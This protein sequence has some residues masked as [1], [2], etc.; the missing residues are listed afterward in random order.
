[1]QM[2]KI[3]LMIFALLSTASICNAQILRAE[4]L[5]KYAKEKFGDNWTDAAINLSKTLNLDKNNAL[6]ISQVIEV[7]NKSK[8][9][10]YIL[11]NYWYSSTFNDANSVIQLNDKESGVI[12]AQGYVADIARHTGGMNRYIVNLSPIIKCDIKEGKARIT[13]TVPFYS[14]TKAAGG[15]LL[16]G[17][18]NQVIKQQ[19][20][21]LD[22]CFPFAKKDS[23]K[24]VSSKALVMAYA[25]S[26]VIM[27]KIE[28]CIKNGMNGNESDDW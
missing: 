16:F 17:P 24:Q 20:W 2:K 1:M 9:D 21:V 27:D 7:P 25:Y 15:G 11:L 6:T 8:Q 23:H 13:Y 10:I 3:L 22:E 14:V 18:G 12:I 4:E 5:E 19:N 26:N 28:E